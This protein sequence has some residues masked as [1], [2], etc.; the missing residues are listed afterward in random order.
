MKNIKSYKVFESV[1]SISQIEIKITHIIKL[2]NDL[3]NYFNSILKNTKVE[4][5]NEI[6]TYLVRE[7]EPYTYTKSPN[8][9]PNIIVEL[10]SIDN[11]KEFKNEIIVD[12]IN[13]Q[14]NLN[15]FDISKHKEKTLN[16]VK[17]I[18]GFNA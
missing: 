3:V 6:E 15:N 17:K 7:F 12:I 5:Y 1:D 10:T 8:T 9:D 18:N 14:I 16:T 2:K 4:K 11:Y 13:D